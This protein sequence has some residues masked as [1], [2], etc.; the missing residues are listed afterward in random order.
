MK[1][2]LFAIRPADNPNHIEGLYFSDQ[3]IAKAARDAKTQ[4]TGIPHVV[5]PGP[6]HKRY[7]A[8][9]EQEN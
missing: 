5:C 8:I 1:L 3:K 7:K 4:E 2:R 9:C 6:D